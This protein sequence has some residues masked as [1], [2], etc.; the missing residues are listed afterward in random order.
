[1]RKIDQMRF[2]NDLT[3]SLKDTIREKIGNGLIPENWDGIEL[4]EYLAELADRSR[5]TYMKSKRERRRRDYDN[6]VLV[7]NL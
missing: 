3:Q 4:R 2:V 7:N 1:M 6:T 5:A